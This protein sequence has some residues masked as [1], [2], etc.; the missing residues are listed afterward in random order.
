DISVFADVPPLSSL[1]ERAVQSGVPA[2]AT[3][4]SSAINELGAELPL[5]LGTALA[6]VLGRVRSLPVTPPSDVYA[7]PLEK[8]RSPLPDWLLPRRTIGAFNVVRALGAGGVSSVFVAR[9]IEERHDPK[10]T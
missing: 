4:L 7:I 5:A 8:R 9:R 2:N 10:A 1:L 3:Q 6:Q